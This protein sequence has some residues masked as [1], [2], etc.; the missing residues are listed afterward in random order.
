M[1][2][3]HF[4]ICIVNFMC[5]FD[6]MLNWF[7]FTFFSFIIYHYLLWLAVQ[8]HEYCTFYHSLQFRLLGPISH[9]PHHTCIHTYT[10]SVLMFE[11]SP[12]PAP[13]SPFET[14]PL[15]QF[16]V[17]QL[18][19]LHCQLVSLAPSGFILA[20]GFTDTL[21]TLSNKEVSLRQ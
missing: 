3:H 17:H 6:C 5:Y 15:D 16:T 14:A 19:S 10:Q 1:H 8:P 11:P 7:S 4:G 20:Q 9:L 21:L 13:P 18:L 12:P 2:F